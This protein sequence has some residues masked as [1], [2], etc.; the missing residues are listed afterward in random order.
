MSREAAYGALF[1][2]LGLLRT[3]GAVKV[4]DRKVKA[5][6]DVN[7]GE[8]P[9]LFMGVSH[10][11]VKPR[12][13]MPAAHALKALVYL[14]AAN[15]DKHTAAGVQLNG[16]LDAVERTLAPAPGEETQTLGGI[17]YHAWIEGEI[18][19]FE[20][21]LGERAAAIVPVVMLVP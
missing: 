1:G 11:T 13:G 16:L 7:A 10:Q 17:V 18:E 2:L 12:Q 4:C 9:A 3:A 20:G 21:V 8:L 6:D 15:P 5:I 19:V 14:Y